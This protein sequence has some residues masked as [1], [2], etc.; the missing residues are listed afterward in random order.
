MGEGLGLVM[1]WVG[2]GLTIGVL[3]LPC[4]PGIKIQ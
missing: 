2:A 3:S 1:V 4:C